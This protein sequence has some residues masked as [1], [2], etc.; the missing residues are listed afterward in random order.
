[1]SGKT[2]RLIA[3]IAA[4]LFFVGFVVFIA[5]EFHQQKEKL[6]EL[7]QE[8]WR[9]Q[10][11]VDELTREQE[12][13]QSDIEFTKSLE[14]LLQYARDHLGYIEPGDTRIDDGE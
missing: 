4:A 7:N 8:R 6:T 5:V 10:E 14:G 9:L 13:L 11:R 3:F 1:M 2:L 12:R